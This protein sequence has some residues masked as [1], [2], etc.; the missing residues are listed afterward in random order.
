MIDPIPLQFASLEYLFRIGLKLCHDKTHAPKQNDDPCPTWSVCAAIHPREP[1]VRTAHGGS[2]PSADASCDLRVEHRQLVIH[3]IPANNA[4]LPKLVSEYAKEPSERDPAFFLVPVSRAFIR[5]DLSHFSEI[6]PV[7]QPLV[8]ARL[9]SGAAFALQASPVPGKQDVLPYEVI[10][11]GDG[12]VLVYNWPSDF[13]LVL[14]AA[15]IANTFERGNASASPQGEIHFR[16]SVTAGSVYTRGDIKGRPNYVGGVLNESERLISCM[17][18]QVEDQVYFSKTVFDRFR[19]VEE[20]GGLQFLRMGSHP[21][22]HGRMHRIYVL[23][24]EKYYQG[25]PFLIL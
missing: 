17:P 11:T 18:A 2:T 9:N 10:D 23:Q 21:D 25:P 7:Y 22:K 1:V 14:I 6:D 19:G 3:A 4:L 8:L 12:F 16:M 20:H 24:Y 15:A 13:E 5:L